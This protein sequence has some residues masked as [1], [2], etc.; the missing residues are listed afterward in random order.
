MKLALLLCSASAAL[1]MP[2][3]DPVSRGS[4]QKP[5]L[6]SPSADT[7]I[8][9]APT[10]QTMTFTK[11]LVDH[12]NNNGETT[13]Q[14]WSQRFLVYDDKFDPKNASAP[15]LFYAGNEGDITNF[16][17]ATGFM[18]DTMAPPTQ[19]LVV[20]GEHRYFGESWPFETPKKSFEQP[21]VKYL[22]TEQ[23]QADFV[24]LVKHIKTLTIKGEVVGDRAVIVFGGSYGGMLAAWLRMKYPN[25][26]AG[27]HA[28]SAPILFE[29]GF[30]SPY[31]FN[32]IITE[33]FYNV[34]SDCSHFI[35]ENQFSLH[36][37]I[38]NK[39]NYTAIGTAYNTCD[40]ITKPSEIEFI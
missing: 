8:P 21:N 5:S 1:V 12:F 18:W 33:N 20:F 35:R 7:V 6:T 28:A 19:G 2:P 4:S 10:P 3:R 38:N 22:T 39:K 16:Y 13:S 15:I 27:A 23:A 17:D 40:V 30:I 36:D 14:E 32:E 37:N 11:Q 25:V 24:Q 29:P 31:G 9:T 26:F 34:S